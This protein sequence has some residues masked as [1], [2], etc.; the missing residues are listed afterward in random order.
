MRAVR[1]AA[2]LGF[3][4]DSETKKAVTKHAE[5]LKNVSAERIETELTK[6]LLSKHPEE[7]E[8]LYDLGIT[9]VI[10]PEFDECMK[11][12]Q[13]TPYHLYDVGHHIIEVLKNVPATKSLRYAALFHDIGKPEVRT[14]DENGVDHFKGHNEVS[15]KMAGKILKRL[16]MDNATINDVKRIVLWHDYGIYGGIK[17]NTLRRALNKMGPEYFDSYIIIRKAD[18][19]GQSD[20][21]AEEK[22]QRLDE[23]IKMHDEIVA[24]E[25]ALS[26]K[27]LKIGGKDLMDI[28]VD[29]GPMIGKILNSLLDCVMDEPGLNEK[30]KLIEIVKKEWL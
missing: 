12:Q 27:D 7:V 8:E 4:I 15:E 10:L 11:T 1:F 20:H 29:K 30:E 14:T 24:S 25:E 18:M 5:E 26:L 22:Q 21:K 3:S 9:A 28:G 19:A 2:Q 13:N 6:L 17:K 23:I 16:K